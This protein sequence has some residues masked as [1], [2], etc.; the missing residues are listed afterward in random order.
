[1]IIDFY[2]KETGDPEMQ[3]LI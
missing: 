2:N 1:M 3:L